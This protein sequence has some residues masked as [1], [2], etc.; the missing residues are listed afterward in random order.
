MSISIYDQV[1]TPL[2]RSLKNFDKIVTKAEAFAEEKGIDEVVL[3]HARL[4][5]DMLPF[6]SQVRIATDT[7]KGAAGRL[8]GV[9]LPK[10]ADDEAT[11]EEV[12]ERIGKAIDFLGTFKPEQFEGS[13]K[14]DIHL[15][16]GPV[17][18]N[19][20]GKDYVTAFVLPNFYFHYTTAYDILRFN[21]LDIGKRDF[22]G[23]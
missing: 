9:D 10:W 23:G 19:F 1:V 15:K 22:L 13:E 7:A 11:F 4:R 18:M 17:E 16:F 6:V 21:G 5:P 2:T 14:K 3:V 12:H 8:G 20:I